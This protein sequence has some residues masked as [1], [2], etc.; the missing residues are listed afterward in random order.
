MDDN[1]VG[2]TFWMGRGLRRMPRLFRYRLGD[3]AIARADGGCCDS[4]SSYGKATRG[5]RIEL[6]YDAGEG[7]FRALVFRAF[8]CPFSLSLFSLSSMPTD[9]KDE[10]SR[11]IVNGGWSGGQSRRQGHFLEPRGE[12][13]HGC[14][15]PTVKEA[16]AFKDRAGIRRHPDNHRRGLP[17]PRGQT[18]P[19][20][21]MARQR[22][23]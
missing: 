17:L 6:R 23:R 10:N 22:Q 2:S 16:P 12:P 18:G 9:V 20:Q 13:I 15:I 11:T 5:R 7:L 14:A 21:K 8:A 3:V 4:G 1:R 19:A